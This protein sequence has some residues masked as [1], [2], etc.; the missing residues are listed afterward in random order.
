MIPETDPVRQIFLDS[1]VS[2][3]KSEDSTGWFKE[4]KNA[5]HIRNLAFSYEFLAFPADFPL[6][7]N[8][9]R[10]KSVLDTRSEDVDW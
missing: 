8:V 4:N 5:E 6:R 9:E 3:G 1:T 7:T 2:V 10:E